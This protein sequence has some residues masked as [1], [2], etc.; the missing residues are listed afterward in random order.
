M[1]ISWKE[2]ESPIFTQKAIG[3]RIKHNN[4]E[5]IMWIPKSQITEELKPE[6]KMINIPDWLYD[7]KIAELFF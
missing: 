5:K 1:E 3:I 7:K 2:N 4:K 6:F